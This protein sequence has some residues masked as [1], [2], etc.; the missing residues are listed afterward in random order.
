MKYSEK[1]RLTLFKILAVIFALVIVVV[2]VCDFAPSK[3]TKKI[4][5]PFTR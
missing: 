3:E 5:I 4:T 2:A 1:K